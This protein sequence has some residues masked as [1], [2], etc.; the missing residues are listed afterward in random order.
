MVVGSERRCLSSAGCLLQHN[1]NDFRGA[2]EAEGDFSEAEAT[3]DDEPDVVAMVVAA[4]EAAGRVIMRDQRDAAG[5]AELP[6]VRMATEIEVRPQGYGHR[7]LVR[8][9]AHCDAQAV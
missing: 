9:V 8:V 5:Q 4:G 7:E 3:V 1:L 2:E 6:A